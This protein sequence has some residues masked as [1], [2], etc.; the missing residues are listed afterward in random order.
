VEDFEEQW[1]LAFEP[2]LLV[3]EDGSGTIPGDEEARSDLLLA[4]EALDRLVSDLQDAGLSQQAADVREFSARIEDWANP[5]EFDATTAT[6]DDLL[7]SIREVE[8]AIRRLRPSMTAA[9]EVLGVC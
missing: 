3:I 6:A 8:R 2:F 4:A 9:A 7:V 5:L 1:C